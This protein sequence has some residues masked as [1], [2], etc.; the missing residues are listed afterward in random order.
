MI[1]TIKQYT[2]VQVIQQPWYL[3]CFLLR[4][5]LYR[6]LSKVVGAFQIN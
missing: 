3:F 4:V 5:F 1:M 6:F 2:G